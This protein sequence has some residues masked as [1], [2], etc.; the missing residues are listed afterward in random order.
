MLSRIKEHLLRFDW[1]IFSS[2][3]LLSLFGLAEIYS[4]ALG[5]ESFDLANFNKQILYIA[6]GVASVFLISF[7]DYNAIKSFSNYFYIAGIIILVLVLIFGKTVR[8]TTGWFELGGFSIQP[9][10]FAKIILIIFL[11]K[12]FSNTSLRGRPF[13]IFS[14]S[15]LGTLLFVV[16]VLLQPD[17]GPA[18]IMLSVWFLMLLL[19]GV[20]KW[21]HLLMAIVPIVLI[22]ILSWSFYLAPY[23][24]E[25]ILVFLNPAE[26]S[27]G[28]GY[29]VSQALI[30]VGSGGLIGRGI[31]F[32]SQSQLKFLP[33]AQND[34]I[35]SVISEEL[36]F[37][38]SSLLIILFFILFARLLFLVRNIKDDFAVFFILGGLVLI[39]IQMFIN[40]GMNIGIMPV[41][42]ISLPFVS[43]GGSATLASF[44]LIGLMQSVIIGSKP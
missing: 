40:I 37:F 3:L 44:I 34:F 36:G 17:F 21:K 8:S 2:V 9:V 7:I 12:F 13:K 27:L 22:S 24:K 16:L 19:R 25:R 29:N 31:G 14:L 28:D 23:Q 15:L 18:A 11:A 5:R 26:D 43:Y 30:A 4:V 6:L 38:G 39:F 42:G 1:I 10:E 32:G 20:F 35:F 33:E 41:V